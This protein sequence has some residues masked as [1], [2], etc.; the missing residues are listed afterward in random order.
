MMSSTGTLW[1]DSFRAAA[2]RWWSVCAALTRMLTA[3]AISF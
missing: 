2:A 1:P 3:R